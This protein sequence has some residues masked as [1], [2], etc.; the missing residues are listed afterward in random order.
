M[1]IGVVRPEGGNMTRL[2]LICV[3]V[4]ACGGVGVN[5]L[6]N[7]EIDALCDRLA[8]CGQI[9]DKQTCIDVYNRLFND[10]QLK[11]GVGN[12]SITYDD[13]K[14]GDC[15]DAIRGESCDLSSKDNR[16][17]PESCKDAV[18][19]TRKQGDP[20][21]FNGECTSNSC[22]APT[23]TCTMACCA[24]TCNADPPAAVAIGKSCADAP[25]VDGAYCDDT[26]TC[27]ALIAQNAA[28]ASSSNCTYGT[29]CAGQTGALTCTPTPKAGD[30]CLLEDGAFATCS[31]EGLDCDSTNHCVALLDKGATCGDATPPCK[32]DL[33][34]DPSTL[35]CGSPPADGQA[36]T[37]QCA[38]P[39]H[40]V[41]NG[42]TGQGTCTAPLANGMPC[43][44]SSDCNSNFCDQ[45]QQT[46]VCA[47][48]TV[49]S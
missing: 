42:T 39:D 27:V 16:V 43:Q 47:D 31:T 6:K 19:G 11:A 12:G 49:C 7:Q 26:T 41:I 24:G 48:R 4:S 17:E 2:A 25:C 3:L 1:I 23:G 9:S 15:I 18:K 29:I 33:T 36:C 35:K 21:Y 22:A 5:D 8:R 40:C 32:G 10:D 13:G 14:A 37:D 20:C 45:S 38:S 46:P 30:T 44:S 34:C 28:C